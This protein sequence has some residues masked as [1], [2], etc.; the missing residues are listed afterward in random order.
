M[1]S[2]QGAQPFISQGV[3][4]WRHILPPVGAIKRKRPPPSKSLA[5]F[6]CGLALRTLMSERGMGVSPPLCGGISHG[7]GY[8]TCNLG[9][10]ASPVGVSVR[11]AEGWKTVNVGK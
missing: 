2:L 5:G 1:A 8:R 10:C 3:V 11:S 4:P 9:V 7:G 6:C